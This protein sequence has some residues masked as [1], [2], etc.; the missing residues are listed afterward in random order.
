[1][2][3]HATRATGSPPLEDSNTRGPFFGCGAADSSWHGTQVA[4]IIGAAANNGIGMAGTAHGVRILPVR[5]LGKCGG[6]DSDI[7]AGSTGPQGATRRAC[8][9]AARRRGC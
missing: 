7:V 1:M 5:V 4:G 6:F 3:T 8:P 2:P 9:A